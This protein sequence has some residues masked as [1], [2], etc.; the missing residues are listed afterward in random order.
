M[1]TKDK[2]PW[3]LRSGPVSARASRIPP[4]FCRR[5]SID[6]HASLSTLRNLYEISTLLPPLPSSSL[7]S[8]P[9]SLP[10]ASFPV[11][12]VRFFWTLLA[13]SRARFDASTDSRSY[14]AAQP[15]NRVARSHKSLRIEFT[16]ACASRSVTPDQSGNNEAE[17]KY[18]EE[19]SGSESVW[20]GGEGE[21]VCV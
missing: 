15:T 18:A 1:Q 20:S 12:F 7:L 3:K 11:R 16:R 5:A 10:R 6:R 4:P 8:L 14:P 2:I 19:K 17:K 13:E 9:L 21:R